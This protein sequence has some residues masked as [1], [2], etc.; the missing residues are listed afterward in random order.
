M[1]VG[2][3]ELKAMSVGSTEL[4]AEAPALRAPEQKLSAQPKVGA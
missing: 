4:K 1:S 2:S 3:T